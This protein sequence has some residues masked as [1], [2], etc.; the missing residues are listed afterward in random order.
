MAGM[1]P[2]VHTWT[3]SIGACG[4]AF[5]TTNKF[6]GW[7]GNMLVGALA[8]AHLTRCEIV[9]GKVVKETKM[10]TGMGRVRNVKQGPDG[11]IYVSVEGPGRILQLSPE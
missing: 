10:L 7:K 8:L 1:E 3:P 11:N 6:K 2:P 5:I 4:L 9:S